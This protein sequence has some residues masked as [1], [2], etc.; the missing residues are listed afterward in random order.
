MRLFYSYNLI[1]NNYLTR[2][3]E[4]KIDKKLKSS[5]AIL[6]V[7]PKYCGKTTTCSIFKKSSIELIDNRII[8]IV[9]SDPKNALIGE[10]PRLIDEWQNVPELW[11]YIRKKVDDDNQFGEFILTGSATPFI[12]NK[13]YHSGAGRIV[14]IKMRTMSLYESKDSSGLISIK[15]MF[16]NKNYEIFNL[17]ENSSLTN[18]AYLICRGGWPHSLVE[19]KNISLEITRNYYDGLFNFDNNENSKYKNKKPEILKMLLRSYARN[20]ST[21]ASYQNILKDIT[22]SNARNIDIKTFN[23]YLDIAKDLFIIED[24]DAWTPNLRS[25][26]AI[27]TTPTRHFVDTSIACLALNISKD[28]LMN[29]ANTFGLFFEDFAIRDLR[30]YADSLDGEVRHFRDSKGLECDAIIHLSD[31]RWAAIEIKLGSE[32]GIEEAAKNLIKLENELDEKFKKPSFKMILI[33]NGAAYRRKDGIYVV[34]IN[35]LKN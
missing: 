6:V 15:E 30:I 22:E 12:T 3:I 19:D 13:I 24:I 4:I 21:E 27:R 25:K 7:G 33:A 35:L 28:D 23:S 17:N 8:D 2:L 29:D 20:I 26:S 18:I 9:S 10:Y 31:G 5:G 1:M 16:D 32:K 11:N 34:P 14:T